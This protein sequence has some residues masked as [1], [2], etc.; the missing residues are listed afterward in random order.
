[1]WLQKGEQARIRS[2]KAAA[3]VDGP[4]LGEAFENQEIGRISNSGLFQFQF[5]REGKRKMSGN[6]VIAG[7][8]R[9][10]GLEL[11]RLMGASADRIDVFARGEGELKKEAN[12][13]FHACDFT[14]DTLQLSGLPETIQGVAYC[15]GSINLRPFRSLK[16]DDFRKDLEINLVGAVKF[17][18]ACLPGLK[19]GSLD[20]PASVVL[21]STVAVGQGMPMHASVAAAKGAVEGLTRSL[22]AELAPSIRV[23]CLAPALT[24]TSLTSRFFA[25]DERR[26][27]MA[28]KYPMGRTGLPADLAA[29]ARFLLLPDSGW[30]TGQVIGVDG[31]MS[32]LRT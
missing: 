6:F 26:K 14:G 17:L 4:R 10:I 27:A 24:E 23:N 30:I 18:Q 8:S 13:I 12:T 19:K 2:S 1:M 32:T 21:F 20:F 29:L 31:G 3:L 22:A 11:V 7:G 15:P 5:I 16:P 9:G 25:S 28:D